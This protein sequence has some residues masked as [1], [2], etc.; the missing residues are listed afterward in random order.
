MD[1]TPEARRRL[2]RLMSE[3]VRDLGLAWRE[4]AARAGISY[5]VIRGLR[6]T[7]TGVR[8]RTLWHL[9]KALEWEGGS[10]YRVLY[11]GGDPVDIFTPEERR[12]MRLYPRSL[13]EGVARQREDEKQ[14]NGASA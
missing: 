9:D 1:I 2:D 4:V 7:A 14:T 12:A 11:E 5:E 13:A 8:D 6:T 10:C 3:R